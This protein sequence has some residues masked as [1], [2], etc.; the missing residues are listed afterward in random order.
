MSKC[1]VYL[2]LTYICLPQ[3][4]ACK[5]EVFVACR[6]QVAFSDI[7]LLVFVPLSNILPMDI[8]WPRNMQISRIWQRY[9]DEIS[10]MSQHKIVISSFILLPH[11]RS[12]TQ[13]LTL[14]R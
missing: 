10:V 3:M 12:Q 2:W 7:Y 4:N 13:R 9:L 5:W 11:T 6:L 1:V 8:D 14:A